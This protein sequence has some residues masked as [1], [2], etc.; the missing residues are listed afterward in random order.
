MKIR[1]IAC[2]LIITVALIIALSSVVCAAEPSTD[3]KALQE[4]VRVLENENQVLREDLG[5]ARLDA[6]ADLE[7]ASKRQAEMIAKTNQELADTKAQ[8][9]ADKK[10]QARRN[11][12]LWIGIAVVAIG[13][14][15][16]N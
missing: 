4:R 8:M 1:T 16:S 9:E 10:A 14:L 5:K 6:R 15:A 2:Y 3:V 13:A 11:R 7:A 12:N